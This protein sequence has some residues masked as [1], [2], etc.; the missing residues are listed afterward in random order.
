MALNDE[1]AALV[2]AGVPLEQGLRLFAA[3]LDGRPGTLAARIAQRLEQGQSL[4]DVLADP[5]LGIPPLYRTVVEAGIRSGRLATALESIARS[6]RA[7]SESRR[8]L[9]AAMIY[10][11]L[12][13]L[14]AWISFVWFAVRIAPTLAQ[15]MHEF[16]AIGQGLLTWLAR[17]G[18]AAGYWGPAVPLGT[19]LLAGVWWQRSVRATLVQPPAARILIGW[20]PWLGRML[21]SLR[22]AAF[23]EILGMLLDNEVPLDQAVTL[24]AQS[25]ADPRMI[26][27]ANSLAAAIRRGQPF[28]DDATWVGTDCPPMVRWLLVAGHERG[29]L[30][31]S[32]RLAAYSYRRRA[33]RQAELARLYAPV[34]LTL[35]VGGSVT[36]FHGLAV[37]GPWVSLLHALF[38]TS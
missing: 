11:L 27:S 31:E 25:A 24:A 28:G 29:A 23:A 37:F 33:L 1:I 16:G 17:L 12:L 19:I 21:R 22:V 9:T 30:L 20:L 10:P 34:A 2:R 5:A 15:G 38:R 36:L 8:M 6:A 32:L 3:E 26:R 13:L 4:V 18:S 7:L 35:V 14:V